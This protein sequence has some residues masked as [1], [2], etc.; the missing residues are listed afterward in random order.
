MTGIPV[1]LNIV[2]A[3]ECEA[4]PLIE[5]LG[6]TKVPGRT[7]RPL[8]LGKGIALTVSGV[9]REAAGMAV[10]FLHLSE[11]IHYAV[12]G[13]KGP[14]SPQDVAWLNVG[15]G[16]HRD[17]PLGQGVLAHRVEDS[18]WSRAWYPRFVF[19]PPCPT[20][21]VRTIHH[22][23]RSYVDPVVYE[24]EAAGFAAQASKVSTAELVHVYK[25]I[26]DGPD[27]PASQINKEYVETLVRERVEEI[28]AIAETLSA[29]AVELSTLKADPP[30]WEEFRARWRFTQTQLHQ[31]RRLLIQWN[32]LRPREAIEPADLG[33]ARTPREALKHLKARLH[34]A[35]LEGEAIDRRD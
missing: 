10:K 2:T 19:E 14:A 1:R 23:E 12:P 21:T 32:A 26:S 27:Q 4:R 18:G 16:G 3:L 6:L 33:P 17:L 25:I 29:L 20:A 13:R 24:M 31:L 7:T 5:R 22:V 35:A 9:G 28:A 34:G 11:T 15:I 8:Y 30:G